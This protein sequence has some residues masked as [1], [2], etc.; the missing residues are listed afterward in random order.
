M[1]KKKGFFIVLDGIDGSGKATQTAL[2]LERLKKAGYKTG[3]I[4]FPQYYDNFFG[5]FTGEY[6]TGK[7][8]DVHPYLASMLYALDRWESKDRIAKDLKEGKV[9]VCNRYMSANMIHQGGRIRDARKRKE[10]MEFL[11]KMEFD[12]FGIPKP[13]MVFY[14]DVLPEVGQKLVGNKSSRAYTKGKKRDIHEKDRQHLINARNQALRLVK[15]NKDWKKIDCMRKKE[16][17]PPE[18]ISEMI[19]LETEKMLKK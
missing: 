7:L 15:E 14:L 1:Q 3:T 12:I 2:L 6:L 11:R 9:F 18:V 5:K 17:L 10:M 4:D 8:G 16:I 13:D 19:W